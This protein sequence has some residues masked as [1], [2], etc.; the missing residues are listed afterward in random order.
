MLSM[1]NY[2][3]H[4]PANAIIQDKSTYFKVEL[5]ELK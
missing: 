2:T 4:F 5:S 1:N 3:W